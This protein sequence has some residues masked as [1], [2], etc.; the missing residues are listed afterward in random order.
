MVNISQLLRLPVKPLKLKFAIG[1]SKERDFDSNEQ[2][3]AG[4]IRLVH[5]I[6]TALPNNLE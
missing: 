6:N 1:L 5:G 4:I 2:T 3:G